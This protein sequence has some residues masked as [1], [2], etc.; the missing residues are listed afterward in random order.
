[1]LR[2]ERLCLFRYKRRAWC[3]WVENKREVGM[4]WDWK[5]GKGFEVECW[6]NIKELGGNEFFWGDSFGYGKVEV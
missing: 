1:M 6:D 2:S 3:W 5:G 4:R